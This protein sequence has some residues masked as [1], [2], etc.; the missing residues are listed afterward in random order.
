MPIIRFNQKNALKNGTKETNFTLFYDTFQSLFF[1]LKFFLPP[2][3][4]KNFT[5]KTN[6]HNPKLDPNFYCHIIPLF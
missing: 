3:S 1:L 2:K 6:P 4:P 5:F